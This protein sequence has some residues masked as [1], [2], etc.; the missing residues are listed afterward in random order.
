MTNNEI[1]A[2]TDGS[3]LANP[4]PS[5]W[6]WY[7]DENT[8]DSGGW[9]IATNNIA[10]LTAVRELLIATRHTDRPILILSDSKYVINS[11]TKWVYSWK[12]RKW[13]KADGKPVLNQ[14]I[15]QEID[16]LMENRNIRMSWVNAHTGHPLNEAADSLARQAA[17]NFSTRSAHIPGPGWTERSAK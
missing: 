14:E 10:E 8:W 11:L 5:G 7:V 17:N 16:S 2:A 15:I 6:A 1:I 9:D 13:R 12:M 3:S 4:G